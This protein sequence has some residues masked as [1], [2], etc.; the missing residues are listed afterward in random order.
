M[1]KK[2]L[3]T[4]FILT[5]KKI[6]KTKEHI[7]SSS[8]T[9][10]KRLQSTKRYVDELQN[11]YSKL[12][13]VRVDLGYKKPHS[14]DIMLDDGNRD[15]NK[16]LNNR[17]GK[18]SVFKDQVGYMCLKEFTEDKGVHLHTAF[19][20]DGSKV[21]KDAYKGDQIGEYWELLTDG[22]GS[23]HNCNREEYREKGVG[24]LHYDDTDKREILDKHV[25]SYLCKDDDKQDISPVK[26]NSKDRAFVRGIIPKAKSKAGRPRNK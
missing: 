7:M 22:K 17:R 25:I 20:Y 2:Y 12:C 3:Y 14:E 26:K 11:K 8:K 10:N 6:K 18:P 13:I 16:M 19:F 24:M 1:N 15:F 4:Y 9:V 23:Y 21:H 5:Y